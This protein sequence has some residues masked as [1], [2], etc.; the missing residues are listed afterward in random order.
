M[1]GATPTHE[2]RQRVE[3]LRR[4]LD[5]HNYR[6]YVLDQPS[7]SDAAYDALF[8]ELKSLEEQFPELITA[9]SPT[10]NVGAGFVTTTFAPIR[11]RAPMLSLS[12]AFGEEELREWDRR[13]KR[14]LGM[15]PDIA[16]EYVAE[17]KIDGLSISLTY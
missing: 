10:Q 4:E 16:I 15:R 2:I 7:V 1:S 14:H 12:N 8:N 3:E 17:L 5:D 11:H 9:D 6:Y 13:V